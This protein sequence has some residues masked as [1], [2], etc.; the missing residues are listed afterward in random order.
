[1]SAPA[2]GGRLQPRNQAAAADLVRQARAEGWSLGSPAA[3]RQWDLSRLQQVS[4]FN[5]ADMLLTVETGLSLRKIKQ[6]AA[7]ENLW[8]PLDSPIP[9]LPLADL[10][11]RDASLSWLSHRHGLA[12]DRVMSLTALDD[13]GQAVYSGA[14]VVKNVAG[15]QL[16]P[17][18]IGAWHSLGPVMEVSFRLSPQPSS[19][20]T[21]SLEA[22]DH[23]PLLKL[24][25]RS[26]S[27]ESAASLGPPW[28]A[29]LIKRRAGQWQ[30]RGF[31]AAPRERTLGWIEAAGNGIQANVAV[32]NQPPDEADEVAS[33]AS[34]LIQVLPSQIV[35][36]LAAL[37]PAGI[38]L[39]CYPSAGAVLLVP[40]AD[41]TGDQPFRAALR[42]A[43]AWG[44]RVRPLSLEGA[45]T[46]D[47]VGIHEQPPAVMQRVKQIL[48]PDRVFGPW[49]EQLW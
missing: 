10:L 26:R 8:L 3:D 2:N 35:D 39:I 34:I 47:E 29:L 46:L 48:D 13:Q 12:R 11:A 44:G 33:K 27:G 38:D 40:T 42:S 22:A 36:L 18:Y 45:T 30:L 37:V 20:T 23:G 41:S 15:Y 49:P 21:V 17:L 16:A 19:L 32:V 5:P 7:A 24:W 6:I 31:T 9:D 14:R 28:E 1:M 4:L 25:T 43:Q